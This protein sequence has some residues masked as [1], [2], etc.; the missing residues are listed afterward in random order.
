MKMT[1]THWY[2][3]FLRGTKGVFR[4]NPILSMGLALPF[5]VVATTSLQSAVALSITTLLTLLP[6][7]MLMPFIMKWIPKQFHWLDYPLCALLAALCVMPTRLVTGAISASLM[8]SVGV[9]FSLL[10]VSSLLFAARDMTREESNLANVLLDVVRLWL[11]I[12]VVLL[13]LGSI[14][15]VL[16]YGTIWGK[17]LPWMKVR[18]SA[19]MVSGVG[20]ILLGFLSALGRKIHRSVLGTWLWI[21]RNSANVRNKMHNLVDHI[22]EV[23][24]EEEPPKQ[25]TTEKVTEGKEQE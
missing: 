13:L 3:R 20:F 24:D 8:D 14:R 22:K 15:E 6:V 21:K 23:A 19:V 7:C 5:A 12:A 17:A 16:G 2:A 9:Y 25:K 11:G 18:F 4:R 1:K 10:C